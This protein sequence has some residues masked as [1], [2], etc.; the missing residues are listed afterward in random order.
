MLP[1]FDLGAYGLLELFATREITCFTAVPTIFSRLVKEMMALKHRE[2]T[3]SMDIPYGVPTNATFKPLKFGLSDIDFGRFRFLA[4][5]SAALPAP[6]YSTRSR[7]RT[8]GY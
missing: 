3:Q 7:V 1:G 6:I 8:L 5:G 2:R 4:S